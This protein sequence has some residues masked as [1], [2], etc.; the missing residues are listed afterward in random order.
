MKAESEINVRTRVLRWAVV[1]STGMVMGWHPSE[2]RAR[3]GVNDLEGHPFGPF[4]VAAL[5]VAE[6]GEQ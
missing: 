4:S 3:S 1:D 5:V 2:D 6:V